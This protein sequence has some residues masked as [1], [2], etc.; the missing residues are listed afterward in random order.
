MWSKLTA[1]RSLMHSRHTVS[2]HAHSHRSVGE[3]EWERERER[4]RRGMCS[5]GNRWSPPTRGTGE[6]ESA[7]GICTENL[8][9]R[10]RCPHG[11]DGQSLGSTSAQTAP[12]S[13]LH[14]LLVLLQPEP[15]LI[16]WRMWL[17]PSSPVP[18]S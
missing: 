10:L 16:P 4:E 8:P 12:Q 5:A 7:L 3:R 17:L 14:S 2:A 13:R 18:L 6:H 9:R 11:K 15:N 1:K